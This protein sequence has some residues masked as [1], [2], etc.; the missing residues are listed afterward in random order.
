M[1]VPNKAYNGYYG[2]VKFEKGVGVFTDVEVA[3]ELANRY[4]YE[5]VEIGEEIK[6]EEIKEVAAIEK[7]EP[8]VEAKPKRTRKAK[9]GE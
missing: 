9:A 8:T 7:S 1:H 6:A 3:K 5:I 4:G 2:G